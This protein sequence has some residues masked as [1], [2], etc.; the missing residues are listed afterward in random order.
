M[1]LP[2]SEAQ[3]NQNYNGHCV[4]ASASEQCGDKQCHRHCDDVHDPRWA[5]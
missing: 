2:V 5:V 1:Q 3:G 4:A